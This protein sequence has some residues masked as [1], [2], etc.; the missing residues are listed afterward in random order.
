MSKYTSGYLTD[1]GKFF[2]H[3]KEAEMHEVKIE[4]LKLHDQLRQSIPGGK[5]PDSFIDAILKRYELSERYDYKQDTPVIDDGDNGE[6][7]NIPEL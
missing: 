6:T 3:R 7:D 1:D 2:A 4:L 5:Y